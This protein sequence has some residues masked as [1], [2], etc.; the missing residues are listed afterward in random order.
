M[1]CH[2]FNVHFF[3]NEVNVLFLVLL[4]FHVDCFLNFFLTNLKEF[5]NSNF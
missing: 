3:I 2:C 5:L 4:F 1:V